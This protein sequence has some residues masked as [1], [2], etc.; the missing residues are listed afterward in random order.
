MSEIPCP[1][2][3]T[4]VVETVAHFPFCTLRCKQIDLGN[5]FDGVY[6]ITGSDDDE[7]DEDDPESYGAREVLPPEEPSG[8]EED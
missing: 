5:W 4:M 3:E 2:C 1:I 6:R 8:F 7:D